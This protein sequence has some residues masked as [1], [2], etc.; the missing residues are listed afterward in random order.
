VSTNSLH[1]LYSTFPDLDQARTIAHRL[2]DENLIACANLIPGVL[3]IYTWKGQRNED[4][5]IILIAKVHSDRLPSAMQHLRD[6]HPYE[7][8]CITAWPL[9]AVD[10]DYLA[11]AI[12]SE[13]K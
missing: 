10:P 9:T 6:L 5:E 4:H 12:P 11:W 8:P 7:L 13:K 2:L 3:S 1:V